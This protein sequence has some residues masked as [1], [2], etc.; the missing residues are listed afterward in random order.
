MS[1][2]RFVLHHFPEMDKKCVW[3]PVIVAVADGYLNYIRSQSVDNNPKIEFKANASLESYDK[4]YELLKDY[5]DPNGRVAKGVVKKEY[6]WMSRFALLNP[7]DCGIKT[8]E[9]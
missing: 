9:E 4:E 7:G 2:E 8:D 5:E 3:Y 1:A 6:Q